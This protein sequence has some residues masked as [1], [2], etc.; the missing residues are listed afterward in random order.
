MY[1]RN[2]QTNQMCVRHQQTNQM[3]V[4]HQKTDI[5]YVSHTEVG[6]EA[7]MCLLAGQAQEVAFTA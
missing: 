1:V 3:C 2:Q 6:G 5:M 7:N 4:R